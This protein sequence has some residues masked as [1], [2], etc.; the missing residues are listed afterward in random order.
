VSATQRRSSTTRSV[1]DATIDRYCFHP[2]T[3]Y[4][5]HVSDDHHIVS[6]C[7]FIRTIPHDGQPVSHTGCSSLSRDLYPSALSSLAFLAPAHNQFPRRRDSGL[8]HFTASRNQKYW[9]L[10]GIGTLLGI[11]HPRS[12]V[13]DTGWCCETL[14]HLYHFT[15]FLLH[16]YHALL[17]LSRDA[18]MANHT[19]FS[20]YL[21]ISVTIFLSAV[22]GAP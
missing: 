7:S 15:L 6:Y 3:L 5:S 22:S 14:F 2:K 1:I 4:A 18:P 19:G 20:F 9:R 10:M 12:G 11:G 16:G 17:I 13:L 21:V 8:L